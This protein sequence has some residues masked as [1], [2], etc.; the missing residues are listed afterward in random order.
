MVK[1]V[2]R[3][4]NQI[5]ASRA[6]QAKILSAI[7]TTDHNGEIQR[8]FSQELIALMAKATAT[9]PLAPEV[10]SA[11]IALTPGVS[12]GRDSFRTQIALMREYLLAIDNEYE[13]IVYNFLL[14]T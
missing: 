8:A 10:E 13:V 12:K 3:A 4:S 9:T 7:H 6:K 14:V 1:E 2:I 11:R 5:Q